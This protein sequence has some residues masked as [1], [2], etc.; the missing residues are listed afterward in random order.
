M[1]EHH[2]IAR[3]LREAFASGRVPQFELEA[4]D[5]DAAYAVQAQL[6]AC[7]PDVAVLSEDTRVAD[8]ARRR[9][10]KTVGGQE[11]MIFDLALELVR[12]GDR[13]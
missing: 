4:V 9:C 11:D 5:A 7:Q 10:R 6:G 3:R 1:A 8:R 12:A 13:R 2:A